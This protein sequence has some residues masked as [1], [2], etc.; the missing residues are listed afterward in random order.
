MDESVQVGGF[1]AEILPF[2]VGINLNQPYTDAHKRQAAQGGGGQNV[3]LDKHNYHYGGNRDKI[4]Y[5]GGDKI[6]Q[7]IL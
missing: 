5:Q 7:H 3:V 1:F 4:R 2:L 6:V